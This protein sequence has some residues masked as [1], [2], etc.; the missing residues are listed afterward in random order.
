MNKETFWKIIDSSRQEAANDPD[1]QIDTLEEALSKLSPED[2]VA[3]DRWMREYHLR[4]YTWELWA[5]AYIIGGGCSDDGFMDFRGW[6]ISKGE[7]VYEAAFADPET[8]VDVVKDEDAGGQIEGFLYIANQVWS[9]KTGKDMDDF[10]Y[11][12]M[13]YPDD[14]SGESWDEDDL[15]KLY[16]KLTK[17]FG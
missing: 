1:V 10:P 8:L 9:E 7:K 4:A 15:E 3:F 14:P 17:K 11:P 5:A 6:L 12:D 2:I 16:P 13:K